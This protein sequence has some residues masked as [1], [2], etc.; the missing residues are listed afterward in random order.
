MEKKSRAGAALENLVIVVIFLVLI[1]TFLEDFAVLAGWP[2]QWRRLLVFT[3]LGFDTFFVAEFFARLFSA[4]ARRRVKE[5]LLHERGWIDFFASVP[6]LL[7]NSGP[8]SYA[9]I[10]GGTSYLGLGGFL[11]V[12]KV[13][14]AVRIAR[15]LRLM[16]VLKIVKQLKYADSRMAQ[17]H[18]A[19]VTTTAI[20]VF[21]FSILGF[22]IVLPFVNAP[23]IEDEYLRR[24]VTSA[25]LIEERLEQ[26]NRKEAVHIAEKSR[27]VLLVKESGD[28]IYSR[29]DNRYYSVNFGPG[30]YRYL[31]RGEYGLFFD[32]RTMNAHQSRDNLL[33]FGIVVLL[34]VIFLLVYSPHFALTVSDPIHVMNK[35][36][37]D[38]SYNLEVK[39]PKQFADDDLFQLA[40]NYNEVY[41]PLKDRSNAEEGGELVDMKMDDFG[42]LFKKD[43]EV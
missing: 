11:N 18:V 28:T 23:S 12:L 9:L 7:L 1:Q 33:Y 29:Y 32:V 8:T 19:K 4:L 31:E 27:D 15:I 14:K 35:G 36:L 10:I 41:L 34:V 39:V 13:V 5:Y 20:A 42:D 16:R 38:K 30:D 21:V 37:A 17:R 24:H 26:G 40:K 22:A 6:L 25:D 2:W 43:E 3:G